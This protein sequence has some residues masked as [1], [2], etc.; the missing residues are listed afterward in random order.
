MQTEGEMQ[1]TLT[2]NTSKIDFSYII[3]D[4][5]FSLKVL[6]FPTVYPP[7]K[8]IL[9]TYWL[10]QDTWIRDDLKKKRI[11]NSSIVLSVIVVHF[12]FES[13]NSLTDIVV[14]SDGE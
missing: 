7:I 9:L 2:M 13:G 5:F 10:T 6:N 8:I 1:N 3:Y 14:I 12:Y 11:Y 4:F